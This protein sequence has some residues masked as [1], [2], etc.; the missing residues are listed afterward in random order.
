MS[1]VP[2]YPL[3]YPRRPGWAEIACCTD[4]FQAVEAYERGCHMAFIRSPVTLQQYDRFQQGMRLQITDP[5]AGEAI[6][7]DV[8]E[9]LVDDLNRAGFDG[10][11]E[12]RGWRHTQNV[13]GVAHADDI[14]GDFHGSFT[15]DAMMIIFKL[16]LH[17]IN[18]DN[19]YFL[20]A[21]GTRQPL[22][23]VTP[24]S[25]RRIPQVIP[26]LGTIPLFFPLSR[27]CPRPHTLGHMGPIL[28]RAP[29]PKQ[30]GLILVKN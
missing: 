30:R 17:S 1:G 28:P 3:L 11:R 24:Q 25:Y 23:D 13:C 19:H 5:E 14:P 18:G 27:D 21:D 7:D 16:L 4:A 15:T 9:W 20:D 26:D 12:S 6:V 8:S 22:R 10:A 2:S 29:R